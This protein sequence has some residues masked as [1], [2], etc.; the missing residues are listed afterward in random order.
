MV[1]MIPPPHKGARK[2]MPAFKGSRACG[3]QPLLFSFSY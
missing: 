1:I 2:V 3:T